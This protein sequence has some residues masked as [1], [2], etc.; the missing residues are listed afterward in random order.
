[1]KI[2]TCGR[3]RFNGGFDRGKWVLRRAGGGWRGE[4][5]LE[6][7]GFVGVEMRDGRGKWRKRGP[8]DRR[9]GLWDL[10]SKS[11]SAKHWI[12]WVAVS[13]Q[14]SCRG[15]SRLRWRM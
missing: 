8:F 1:M 5:V 12:S 11:G 15:P 14:G 13:I 4:G 7:G 9:W 3:G 10:W 2:M 6:G